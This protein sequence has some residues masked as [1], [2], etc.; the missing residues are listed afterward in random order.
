[1]SG[2]LAL[3]KAQCLTF[4]RSRTIEQFVL[5]AIAWASLALVLDHDD[6][7]RGFGLNLT[8]LLTAGS[9]LRPLAHSAMPLT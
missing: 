4:A 1:M 5:A 3:L 7:A 2:R 9:F 6:L 8:A